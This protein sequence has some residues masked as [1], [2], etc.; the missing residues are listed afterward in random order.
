[1]VGEDKFVLYRIINLS[2]KER[3]ED[4]FRQVS[5]DAY[6]ETLQGRHGLVAITLVGSIDGVRHG[7]NHGADV[8]DL[9]VEQSFLKGASFDMKTQNS[10]RP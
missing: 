7:V 8:G 6:L 10:L 1:M 9:K 3:V 4:E 2:S 5:G